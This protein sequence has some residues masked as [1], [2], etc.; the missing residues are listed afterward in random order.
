MKEDLVK[1]PPP[2]SESAKK[3][4]RAKIARKAFKDIDATADEVGRKVQQRGPDKAKKEA[5][6]G[7][8]TPDQREK[9]KVR[10]G[11]V[12]RPNA[13]ENVKVGSGI[14]ARETAP[15]IWSDQYRAAMLRGDPIPSHVRTTTSDPFDVFESEIKTF[16]AKVFESL[17]LPDPFLFIDPTGKLRPVY[18]GEIRALGTQ[19]LRELTDQGY[20]LA[21][22]LHNP[23]EDHSV[24]WYA[25]RLAALLVSLNLVRG[26]LAA[27]DDL[28]ATLLEKAAHIGSE[29]GRLAAEQG[30]KVEWEDDALRGREFRP[31][32]PDKARLGKDKATAKRR[33]GVLRTC[34]KALKKGLGLKKNRR[35]QSF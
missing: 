21:A 6:A 9:L 4:K 23:G 7:G 2:Q 11:A 13:L 35:V 3:R 19:R 27:G 15:H 31:K 34:R 33:E 24:L 25:A 30:I 22:V 16:C 1:S 14:T 32:G 29:L 18:A 26:Q 20:W 12:K 5:G 28:P 8:K 10:Q 17:N